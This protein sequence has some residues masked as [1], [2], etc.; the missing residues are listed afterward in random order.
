[1]DLRSSISESE[2][3]ALGHG[4]A[5]QISELFKVHPLIN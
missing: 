4:Y 5:N 2:H 1:M 3:L